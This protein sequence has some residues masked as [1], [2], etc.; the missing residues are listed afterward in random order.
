MGQ[1]LIVLATVTTNC[2]ST[3]AGTVLLESAVAST[4]G[5]PGGQ[6]LSSTQFVGWRFHIDQ[7][8]SVSHIGGHLKGVSGQIFGALVALDTLDAFPAGAPFSTDELIASTVL[9][10]PSPSNQILVPLS[11][12]LNPGSYTLI[13]GSGHFN[14]TGSAAIP[15]TLSQTLMPPA[16]VSSFITWSDPGNGVFRWRAGVNSNMRFLV[17]GTE[18]G[19]TADFDLSGV[20]GAGDL[21]VWKLKHPMATGSTIATGDADSD[22]DTDGRDFLT[23]QRQFGSGAATVAAVPEPGTMCLLLCCGLLAGAWRKGRG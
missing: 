22:G 11:A 14:A 10:P 8:L 5:I 12:V 18:L 9:T 19:G 1:L 4:T 21:S 17:Q 3:R 6:N 16:T 20:V 13:F 15:N 2:G 7:T 23:W